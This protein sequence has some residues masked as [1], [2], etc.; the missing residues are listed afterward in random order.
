MIDL[1]NGNFPHRYWLFK[2]IIEIWI[3]F[4]VWRMKLLRTIYK[5]IKRVSTSLN[6]LKVNIRNVEVKELLDK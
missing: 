2:L 1:S 6:E 3:R 4:Q 5:L